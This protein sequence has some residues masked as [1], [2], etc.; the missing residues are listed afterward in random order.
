MPDQVNDVLSFNIDNILA[1]V[2]SSITSP[3]LDMSPFEQ[4]V[5]IG[6]WIVSTDLTGGAP[7]PQPSASIE[8]EEAALITDPFIAIPEAR[9]FGSTFFEKNF[10]RAALFAL[11]GPTAG[12]FAISY[13]QIL[14]MKRFIRSRVT[15]TVGVNH[16]MQILVSAFGRAE[17]S[18]V[19]KNDFDFTLLSPVNP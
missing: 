3:A 1:L 19:E 11:Q 16:S 7:S 13:F 17:R 6:W 12:G 18:P 2:T 8:I 5:T 10:G 9:L 14:D 15:T 4:G